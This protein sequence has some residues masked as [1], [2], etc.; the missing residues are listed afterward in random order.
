MASARL[1]F[2]LAAS[3]DGFIFLLACIG[4]S[5]FSFGD[6]FLVKDGIA[7]DVFFA[8]PRAQV[9]QTAALAAEGELRV[10]VRVRCG[11]ADGAAKL[12]GASLSQNTQRRSSCDAVQRFVNLPRRWWQGGKGAP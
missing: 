4:G 9:K 8:G 12:H 1:G 10:G 6:F 11:F 2:C 7:H 3:V 5:A